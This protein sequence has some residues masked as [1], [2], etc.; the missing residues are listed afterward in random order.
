MDD[1]LMEKPELMSW[2]Q[3]D[4][5]SFHKGTKWQEWFNKNDVKNKDIVAM[6]QSGLLF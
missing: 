2:N 1:E 4:F 6:K 3:S 5:K